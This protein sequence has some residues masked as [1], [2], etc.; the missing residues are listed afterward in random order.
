MAGLTIRKLVA[1]DVEINDL[2]I[3]LV[4]AIG[5]DRDLSHEDSENVG[6]STD[7]LDSITAGNVIVLNP[8]DPDN[9]TPLSLEDSLLAIQN[10]N[11]T[12][13]GVAGGRFGDIDDPAFVPTTGSL[14]VFDADGNA[15]E[16]T[17]ANVI[18][19]DTDFQ[20]SVEDIVGGLITDGT[21][22]TVAYDDAVAGTLQVNVDDVFLMNTGDILDS[23]TLT[24]ATG[25]GIDIATG[26]TLTIQDAPTNDNDAVNKAYVDSVAQGTDY[27]ESV[28]AATTGDLG[29][30]AAGAGEGATLTAPGPGANVIDGV[31]LEDDDRVVVKDQTDP[32][33][34]GIYVVSESA[35]TMVLTRAVDQDGVGGDA[36]AGNFAFVENGT[37]NGSSG[38]VVTGSG[39][40]VVDTDPI[41]WTQQSGA[42][43]FTNGQGLILT[44]TVFSL[45]IDNTTAAVIESLDEI[46]FNDVTDGLTKKTTVT[47][48]LSELN[49]V[50]SEGVGGFAV[51]TADNVYENR[52]LDISAD[53]NM[54]GLSITDGDG[55]AGNPTFGLDVANLPAQTAVTLTDLVPVYDATN[56][57]NVVYTIEDIAGALNPTAYVI[58]AGAGNSSGD[59]QL[60]STTSADTMTI[61][62]G[63]AIDVNMT[64]ASDTIEFSLT[65]TGL[66][67]TAVNPTDTIVVFDTDDA[68]A[69]VTRSFGDLLADLNVPIVDTPDN[70]FVVKTGEDP[71][72]YETK[73]FA[74]DTTAALQGA[75]VANGDGADDGDILVGVDV[76]N[77]ADS[78]D[79][80]SA[81]DE[82][83]TFDGTDNV[84]M[85]GQQVADGVTDILGLTGLAISTIND[86]PVMTITDDTRGDKQLSVDSNM[87]SFGENQVSHL[88][89]IRA[90]GNA[91]DADSGYIMPLD[92]TVV[93]ATGHCEN[94]NANSKDLHLF[95]NG[96]DV[97]SV[98]TLAGGANATFADNTID[99][100]FVAGDRIRLRAIGSGT[101]SIQDTVASV[102][103]R[104]RAA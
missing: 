56:D 67:D 23:G 73:V 84:S 92:G 8:L 16:D 64:T 34:N 37:V 18:A 25:A 78:A 31:T 51:E 96:V 19:G 76:D 93:F 15:T 104:W 57:A 55:V 90:V 71:D 44:G 30:T 54:A 63:V 36:S 66:I 62:G 14:V 95:I 72:T 86:N 20:E 97:G 42:G 41:N 94:T 35:G 82:F 102:H 99:L 39:D 98:G 4:G 58:F 38:W 10:H 22:T 13:F 9:P 29:F 60:A 45:S 91:T 68:D 2:G 52:T 101:G 40:L 28:Q 27:K 17:I 49:I 61:S 89:W 21:N 81:A 79:N 74:A 100:D 5:F 3:T 47:D 59:A 53:D 69:P 75:S 24:I 43:V 32:I 87:F 33:Q 11:A 7:L 85:S 65:K 46:A 6:L 48:F 70:G 12:H 83:L 103:V 50:T 26:A 80:M 77:L 88:D 1:T